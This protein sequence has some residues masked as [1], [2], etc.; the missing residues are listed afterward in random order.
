MNYLVSLFILLLFSTNVHAQYTLQGNVYDAESKEVLPFVNITVNNEKWGTTTD[1]D[2][3]FTLKHTAAITQLNCSYIGYEKQQLNTEGKN[4]LNIYLKKSVT[5]LAEVEIRPGENPANRIVRNTVKNRDKHNPKNLPSYKFKSY[6]NFKFYTDYP[7]TH[8]YNNRTDSLL[9]N[10]YLFISES[11]TE[12]MY[13]YPDKEKEI[14]IANKVSGFKNPSFSFFVS[15]LQ[16]F[17]LYEDY[18]DILQKK[19]L[20]PIAKGTLSKYEFTLKDTL[21]DKSDTIFVI[22]FEPL[23][24]KNF[25]GLKGHLYIQATDYVV[26]NLIAE[27]YPLG[28]DDL[29]QNVRIQHRYI[30][31]TDNVWFPEQLNINYVFKNKTLEERGGKLKGEM[32]T[33]LKEILINPDLEKK[34][35][36]DLMVEID[37]QANAAADSIWKKYKINEDVEKE[38]RSYRAIDSISREANLE[39]KM[40]AMEAL[41]SGQIPIRF[42]NLDINKL[43][44]LN[45]YEGYRLNLALITNQKV[46]KHFHV[47]G[48][49]GY[50]FKDKAIKY[51]AVGKL[52]LNKRYKSYVEVNYAQDVYEAAGIKAPFFVKTGLIG[53]GKIREYFVRYMDSTRMYRVS[54][55]S[56]FLQHFEGKLSYT[57]VFK[58][59]TYIYV[60]SNN[61]AQREFQLADVEISLR[62]A[63]EEKFIQSFNQLISVGT[64]YP[65]VQLSY[66]MGNKQTGSTFDYSKW[67]LTA[68]YNR[69]F[70]NMGKSIFQINAGQVIGD[71]PYFGYVNG[72]GSY[73][74]RY[75][76]YSGNSFE[77]MGLNEFLSDKYV[78]LFYRHS[79]G[80]LLF[81]TEKFKPVIVLV[82]NAGW[83]TLAKP[84]LHNG[85]SFRTMEKG[86]QEAGLQI[87]NLIKSPFS[88][89]GLAVFYRMGAYQHLKTTD[90]LIFKMTL[91]TTFGN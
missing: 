5:M 42:V 12:K 76:L 61:P 78:Y 41:V 4:T 29:V 27:P 55:G 18:L 63:Y 51:G 9:K 3:F 45:K 68:D 64:K 90:N 8:K 15:D 35:F 53:N 22:Y 69:I 30:K 13:V 26:Q 43:M 52:H 11:V 84:Y 38:L 39:T 80:H 47:G 48:Y 44:N 14:V 25:E 56:R 81:S 83:G 74:K 23:K 60:Y 65:I 37:K 32:R 19:Y 28:K 57:N 46:S 82:Y 54:A 16:P 67:H 2:G 1:I 86:Y 20:N 7:H 36:N 50:G 33:Y 70:R 89:V 62:F 85:I 71:L 34:R 91:S 21:Y 88:G 6:N 72:K 40:K 77:T 17:G 49:V 87:N 31:T 24:D 58:N 79:F 59:P 66:A 73:D 75:Y 10:T